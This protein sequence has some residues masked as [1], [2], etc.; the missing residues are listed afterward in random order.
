MKSKVKSH[1]AVINT[2]C[3]YSTCTINVQLEHENT[4]PITIYLFFISS[5][6]FDSFQ[7]SITPLRQFHLNAFDI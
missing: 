4:K 2:A 7:R 3:L 5:H 1:N 6:L